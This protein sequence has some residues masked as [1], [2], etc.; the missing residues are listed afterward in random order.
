MILHWHPPEQV[1]KAVQ[2]I[3]LAGLSFL[4]GAVLVFWGWKLYRFALA[5]MGAL[6]GWTIGVLI[7]APLGIAAVFVALPLAVLSAILALFLQQVG[8]FFIAGLWGALLILGAHELIHSDVARYLTAAGA[9]LVVGGLAV[10]FW[11]PVVTFL[12]AMFG[13]WLV[14]SAVAMIGDLVRPGA[15]ARW[16]AAHP[17]I[18]FT[19][20]IVVAAIGLYYQEEEE[21]PNRSD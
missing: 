11:R 19:A 9:F 17:W 1:A 5:L 21:H 3:I 4:A 6:V 20:I 7:A 15:S 10:L 2:P 12:L 14:S 18:T 8:V 13:A 16:E